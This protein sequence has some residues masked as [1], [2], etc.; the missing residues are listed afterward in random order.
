[1]PS[2]GGS[3]VQR[4]GPL[5]LPLGEREMDHIASSTATP[6]RGAGTGN[7]ICEFIGVHNKK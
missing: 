1:M 6:G 2:S 5:Q 4:K 3:N 7:F